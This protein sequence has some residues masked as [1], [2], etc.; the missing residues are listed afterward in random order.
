MISNI[1]NIKAQGVKMNSDIIV[2]KEDAEKGKVASNIDKFEKQTE[3]SEVLTYS[4]PKKLSLEQLEALTKE[5]NIAQEKFI[6][7][8]VEQNLKI[9]SGEEII[10]HYG[11]ELSETSASLLTDIFGSLDAALPPPATTKEGALESIS[12]GGAYSVEAVSQR[13]MHM[14]T[15]FANGNPEVLAEMKLAVQKGFEAAGFNIN[16]RTTMPEITGQTYDYVMNEFAILED[17]YE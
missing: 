3:T 5:K 11:I 15:S 4:P 9:Q 12:S 6:S 16:D 10:N 7:Q 2:K 17:R 13:I 1:Q 8:M 14:A